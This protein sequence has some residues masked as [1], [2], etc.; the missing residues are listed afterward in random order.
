MIICIAICRVV[1]LEFLLATEVFEN[2]EKSFFLPNY[3]YLPPHMYIYIYTYISVCIYIYLPSFLG[4]PCH[5]TP[6]ARHRVLGWT[7]CDV[8]HSFLPVIYSAS[9]VAHMVKH[10]P[11][12]WKTRVQSLGQEDPLEKEMATTPVFL[13]VNPMDG[14]AWQATIHGVTKSQT[15]LSNFN[16]CCQLFIYT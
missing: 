15:Q 7:P 3:L 2:S 16:C 5:P 10:L 4:F 13:P 6:L 9:L 14:G 12:M 8:Y 1:I 11:T